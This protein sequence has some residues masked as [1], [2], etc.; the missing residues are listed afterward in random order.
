MVSE[1]VLSECYD[2]TGTVFMGTISILNTVERESAILLFMC[3]MIR[4]KIF[5]DFDIEDSRRF[6][7]QCRDL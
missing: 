2:I 6:V 4:S 7:G 5:K 3:I 1:H